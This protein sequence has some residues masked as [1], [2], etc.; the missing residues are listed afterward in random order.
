[1]P[2]NLADHDQARFFSLLVAVTGLTGSGFS[3][4]DILW[5][6]NNPPN[7]A[8][9]ANGPHAYDHHLYYRLV[10]VPSSVHCLYSDLCLS[11]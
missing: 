2:E 10:H 4:M 5:Q 9:A 7:P 8:D 1:M 3:F 6:Y 11:S